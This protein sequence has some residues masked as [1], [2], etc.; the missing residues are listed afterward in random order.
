MNTYMHF[1]VLNQLKQMSK[2]W[3]PECGNPVNTAD[4]IAE[5]RCIASG[6][7]PMAK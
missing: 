4:A 6:F 7:T 1:Y 3:P 5:I 2:V